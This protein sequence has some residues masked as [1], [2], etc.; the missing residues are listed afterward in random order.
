MNVA[1]RAI[2]PTPLALLI[3]LAGVHRFTYKKV[4]QDT[5]EIVWRW[6]TEPSLFDKIQGQLLDIRV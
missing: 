2:S 1:T 3:E 6:P 4:T 5:G